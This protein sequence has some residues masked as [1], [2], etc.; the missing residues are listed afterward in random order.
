MSNL[1]LFGRK[2]DLAFEQPVGDNP[3]QRNHVRFW[4]IDKS[5]D[6][7]RPIWIGSASYDEG[8]EFRTTTLQIT[9]RISPDLD[10]ERD[11]LFAD[12]KATG[13]LAEEYTVDGFHKEL[14]GKNGG[15][16]PWYTDGDLSVG[17]IADKTP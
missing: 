13:E 4:K 2:E 14:K 12:L 10:K 7:G 3:R 11:H 1:F 5:D 9:H 6:V 8:V 16:D 17:V 15:G